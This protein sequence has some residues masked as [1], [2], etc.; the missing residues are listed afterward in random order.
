MKKFHLLSILILTYVF[1]YSVNH[2]VTTVGNTFSP[3]N[4]TINQGDTVT[5][6]NSGGSH[7]VNATLSTYP[8]NPEGFGNSVSSTSWTLQ[9]IFSIPGNYDYQCD[10]HTGMGMVGTVV[11]NATSTSNPVL[12]LKGVLDLHGSGNPVYSGT[13]GKAIHLIATDNI[14]DLSVYS[15]D[16]ISN[17]SGSL[18]SS[19]YVLSGSANAGDDILIYRVGSGDSSA[20]FFSDYFATCYSNFELIIPSGTSFP[21]GNGDDPVAL[22]FNNQLIDSLTYL[23]NP[24]LSGPFNGDPYDDSWAHRDSNGTWLFGGKDCDIDGTYNVDSSSCPYPICGVSPSSPPTSFNVT[25]SVN[26]SYIT[27]GSNGIYAGGGILGGAI[28]VPLSDLD[29]DSIWTGVALIDSGASGNYA[30]FNSPSNGNDWST[31]EDLVGLPCANGQFNDR[32]LP[33]IDGDTILLHCFGTC[34]T[35]GTCQVIPSTSADSLI[36]KGI[37]SF[38]LPSSAGK[39]IHFEALYPITD[40]SQYGI[41]TAN[42]GGGSDGQEFTFPNISANAG[43][44][45]LVCRDSLVLAAYLEPDC[46]SS[47]HIVIQADE[48]TGNG[49]DAYELFYNGSLIEVFGDV[50]QDGTGEP[51]EYTNSWAFKIAGNWTYGTPNCTDSSITTLSSNC[52][53][54]F[55]AV[56]PPTSVVNNMSNDILI[57]PNPTNNILNISSHSKIMYLEIYNSLGQ[58]VYE[59]TLSSSN[60]MLDISNFSNDFYIAK[61]VFENKVS[62]VN[63]IKY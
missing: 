41:G 11:V 44:Q 50:N 48:P 1:S 3:S 59:R 63:F 32:S 56:S 49:D 25:F 9:H 33:S 30:F 36:F 2:S 39:A 27:V 23:G 8:N 47:Y 34:D 42:N 14:S 12:S 61:V 15:L 53:Y 43:D 4:I 10:P 26:A 58:K 18:N 16:V 62:I 21:S 13:D 40:L 35:D 54:P 57:Y 60:H 19:E 5:W 17:G 31:K 29:G 52:P 46:F 6:T 22:F 51:W 45:I 24:I 20:N 28:A 38:D 7:N 55:C 37:M